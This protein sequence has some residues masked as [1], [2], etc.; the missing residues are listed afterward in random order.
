MKFFIVFAQFFK[1]FKY[2][3]YST[4]FY[5]CLSVLFSCE[6][7]VT[8]F[9]RDHPPVNF[10]VGVITVILRLFVEIILLF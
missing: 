8:K 10:E 6:A 9:H 4:N 3:Y 2:F 7:T 5:L 1:S